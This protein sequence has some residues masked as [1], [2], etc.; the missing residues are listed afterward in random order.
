MVPTST[1]VLQV[2][3]VCLPDKI[4]LGAYYERTKFC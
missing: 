3:E 4:S 2:Y 1:Q